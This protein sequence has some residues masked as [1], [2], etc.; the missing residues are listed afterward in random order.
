MSYIDKRTS[1]PRPIKITT[2]KSFLVPWKL[3]K[4]KKKV[5]RVFTIFK[6]VCNSIKFEKVLTRMWL[7]HFV[8]LKGRFTRATT[9]SGAISNLNFGG[10][11]L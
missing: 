1:L 8:A 11:S 3:L 7:I 4:F 2:V 5:A 9:K 6:K 10:K